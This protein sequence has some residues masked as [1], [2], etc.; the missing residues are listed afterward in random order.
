MVADN[1]LYVLFYYTD[2]SIMYRDIATEDKV[3]KIPY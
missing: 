3:L 2:L 1:T